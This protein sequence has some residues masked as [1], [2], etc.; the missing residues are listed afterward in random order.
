MK[1]LKFFTAAFF[2]LCSHCLFSQTIT[3]GNMKFLKGE[4]RLNCVI[5]YSETTITGFS[6]EEFKDWFATLDEDSTFYAK[7][8]F[9]GVVNELGNRFLLVGNQPKAKYNAIIRIMQIS[10]KGDVMAVCDFTLASSPDKL[11][12]V[13]LTGDG[14]RIGTFMGLVGDGMNELGEHFGKF[15]RKYTK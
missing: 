14:G 13:Q 3:Q 10:P 2:V 9:S 11:C 8:F 4:S 1:A 7:R 5:D 12:S 6:E 15:L